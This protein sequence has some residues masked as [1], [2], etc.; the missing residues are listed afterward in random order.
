MNDEEEKGTS[1]GCLCISCILLQ[2]LLNFWL[3]AAVIMTHFSNT[4]IVYYVFL[5]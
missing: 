5:R 3:H 1:V 2:Y 4:T